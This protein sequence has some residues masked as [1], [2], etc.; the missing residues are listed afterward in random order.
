MDFPGK[1]LKIKKKTAGEERLEDFFWP[2]ECINAPPEY[3]RE[4]IA[5]LKTVQ[6]REDE[7][8]TRLRGY[9]EFAR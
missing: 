1:Y 5:L 3:F 6:R 7:I 2:A 8:I 9:L 4:C